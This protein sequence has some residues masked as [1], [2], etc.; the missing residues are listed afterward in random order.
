SALSA[1]SAVESLVGRSGWPGCLA[2]TEKHMNWL[3]RSLGFLAL[4]YAA[5]VGYALVAW[6]PTLLDVYQRTAAEHPRL[7]W[8]Y[9]AAVSL[10][11]A[12]LAGTSLAIFISLWRNSAGKERRRERRAKDPSAMSHA[13]R[14]AELADNLA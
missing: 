9:L 7:A 8:A 12:L 14:Q 5:G 4:L 3:P 13:E 10:G 6:T 1:Y 2:Y 11:G